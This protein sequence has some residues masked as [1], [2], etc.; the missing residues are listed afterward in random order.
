M[1]DKVLAICKSLLWCLV[2]LLFPITSG[3][4]SVMLALDTVTAL[5]LQGTFMVL[6]LIPPAIFVFI[7]KWQWKFLL[8]S[9]KTTRRANPPLW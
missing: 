2:V 4:L 8:L 7:G 3:T 5:F 1:K 6:A 9:K